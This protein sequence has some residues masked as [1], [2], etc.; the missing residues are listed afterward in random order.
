METQLVEMVLPSGDHI[1]IRLA[2]IPQIG[3]KVE[4]KEKIYVVI[5]KTWKIRGVLVFLGENK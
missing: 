4:W 2:D 3:D 1:F 5:G